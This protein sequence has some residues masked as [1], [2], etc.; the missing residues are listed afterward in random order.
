MNDGKQKWSIGMK[1]FWLILIIFSGLGSVWLLWM[2]FASTPIDLSCIF[3]AVPAGLLS[4]SLAPFLKHPE[5]MLDENGR[6]RRG[7]R[8]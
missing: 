8:R 2:G 5:R 3:Q 4:F 6:V 1:I 7:F